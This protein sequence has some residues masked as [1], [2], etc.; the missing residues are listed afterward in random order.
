MILFIKRIMVVSRK[1]IDALSQNIEGIGHWGFREETM[2][3]VHATMAH[4]ENLEKI[5]QEMLRSLIPQLAISH[6][7]SVPRKEELFTWMKRIVTRASTDAI[8]GDDNP[9][10]DPRVEDGFW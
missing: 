8:Y 5:T 3:T 10:R 7:G 1:S 6:V 9:F 4:G 2:K